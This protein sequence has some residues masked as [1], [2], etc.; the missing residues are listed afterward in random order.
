LISGN[1]SPSRVQILNQLIQD[2]IKP[3]DPLGE[4]DQVKEYWTKTLSLAGRSFVYPVQYKLMSN[5]NNSGFIVN[6]Y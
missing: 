4:G 5:E 6:Y 2:T 1:I 3:I